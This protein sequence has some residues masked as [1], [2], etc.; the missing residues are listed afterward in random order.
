VIRAKAANRQLGFV[1]KYPLSDQLHDH[2]DERRMCADGFSPYHRH[3]E[4]SRQF[5]RFCVEIV[6]DF[7]VVRKKPKRRDHNVPESLFRQAPEVIENVRPEPGLSWGSASA[8]I[9]QIPLLK[10][11][12]LSHQP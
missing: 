9:D 7:H 12:T 8:L 6:N 1:W 10:S 3:P 11:Q 4:F 5:R 2:S